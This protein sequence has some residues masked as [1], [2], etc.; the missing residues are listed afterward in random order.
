VLVL[1]SNTS[2]YN[3]DLNTACEIGGEDKNTITISDGIPGN[4]NMLVV[5]R[6]FK[7]TVA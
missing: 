1:V 5:T 7:S 6:D 3:T 2:W 4:P